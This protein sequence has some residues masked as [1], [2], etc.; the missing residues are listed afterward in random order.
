MR[1]S[2]WHGQT[3]LSVLFEYTY[4]YGISHTDKQSLSV[5]P[6]AK[7]Q[8]VFKKLKSSPRPEGRGNYKKV[9]NLHDIAHKSHIVNLLSIFKRLPAF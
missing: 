4:G 1:F 8:Y 5:P 2:G 9:L 6:K 7:L 3:C